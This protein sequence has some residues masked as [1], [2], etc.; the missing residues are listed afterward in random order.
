[1]EHIW[2]SLLGGAT[3]VAQMTEKNSKYQKIGKWKNCT[4][5]M[6]PKKNLKFVQRSQ[7]AHVNVTFYDNRNTTRLSLAIFKEALGRYIGDGM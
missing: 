2:K 3:I 7:K 6:I 1:M 4:R 5:Y